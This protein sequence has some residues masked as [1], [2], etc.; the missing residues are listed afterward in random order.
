[1]ITALIWTYAGDADLVPLCVESFDLACLHAGWRRYEDY[2]IVV[3]DDATQPCP[4]E[5]REAC[6]AHDVEWL[7]SDYWRMGSL[8]GQYCIMGMLRDMC[9]HAC[10]DA[11]DDPI[12]V[13]IDSDTIVRG[14][15]WLQR[16]AVDRTALV[17][18]ADDR[19]NMYGM[20]Y[21]LRWGLVPDIIRSL[22]RVPV[23]RMA[24]E[25]QIIG[26]RA[27]LLGG[28]GAWLPVPMWAPEQ[29]PHSPNG[30]HGVATPYYWDGR[31]DHPD[32][33]RC[34]IITL[35]TSFDPIPRAEMLRVF[36]ELMPP[37]FDAFL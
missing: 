20:C 23:H 11:V 18:G 30:R 4:P 10:A 15:E 33:A 5:T 6:V 37:P 7:E 28:E 36:R 12:V 14:V 2:R 3:I 16:F 17:T 32:Y 19:G 35:G 31:V 13:K 9:D 8:N 22:E 26:Y 1:M 29:L 25:D 21:A 27:R 24:P 34:E